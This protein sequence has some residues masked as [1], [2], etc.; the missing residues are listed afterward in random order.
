MLDSVPVQDGEPGQKVEGR[1][2]L[3]GAAIAGMNLLAAVADRQGDPDLGVS[4]RSAAAVWAEQE[5]EEGQPS[6]LRLQ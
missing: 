6:P 3:L 2:W 1:V 5:R 4:F